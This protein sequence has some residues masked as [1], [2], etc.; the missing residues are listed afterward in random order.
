M[1]V[2][3]LCKSVKTGLSRNLHDF[4]LCIQHSMHCNVWCDKNLCG[5]NLCDWRLTR[6]ICIN[7]TCAEKLYLLYYSLHVQSCYL[8]LPPFP[9]CSIHCIQDCNGLLF[10][11][12]HCSRAVV[13][14]GQVMAGMWKRNGYS[15]VNQIINYQFHYSK[16]IMYDRDILMLQVGVAF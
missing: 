1:H 7:K 5:T 16:E 8:N 15:V 11:M 10:L 4:Y 2:K 14:S 6:I 3:K 13:M 12:E 9:Q